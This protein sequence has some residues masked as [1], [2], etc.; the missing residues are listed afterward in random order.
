MLLDIGQMIECT[1][2][3]MIVPFPD[4]HPQDCQ[5][6]QCH[7]RYQVTQ[8]NDHMVNGIKRLADDGQ[9]GEDKCQHDSDQQPFCNQA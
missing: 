9:S 2:I 1:T 3:R 7:T 8:G 5:R 4:P 6:Q